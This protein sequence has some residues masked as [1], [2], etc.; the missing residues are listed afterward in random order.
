MRFWNKVVS[1]PIGLC[2]EWR[3]SKHGEGYGLF[4][5]GRRNYRAHRIMW[6]LFNDTIS[7]SALCVLHSCDNPGCVNPGHLFLGTQGDNIADKTRKGRQVKGSKAPRAKLSEG[8][9]L[10]IVA[11]YRSGEITERVLAAEYGVGEEC[12]G[13][14]LRGRFWGHVTGIRTAEPWR[15]SR[16]RTRLSE[17]DIIDIRK[18]VAAG[19]RQAVIVR[20]YR[21]SVAAISN[22][23]QRKT[24]RHV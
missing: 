6:E 8:Q 23:I 2:W 20:E 22:I 12:I 5:A 13:E 15:G 10:E 21:V 24:W 11:R 17:Q 3:G 19:T 4:K 18:R 14:I 7:H 9:V 1:T 16:C